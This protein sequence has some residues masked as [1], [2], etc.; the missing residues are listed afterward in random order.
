MT[1]SFCPLLVLVVVVVVQVHANFNSKLFGTN[2][3]IKIPVPQ[4]TA[5][6]TINVSSTR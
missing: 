5:K 3:V 4:N 2:V 1:R 6:T